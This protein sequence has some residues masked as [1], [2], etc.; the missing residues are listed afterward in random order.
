MKIKFLQA[1]NGD[2]FLLSYNDGTKNRNIL[3]DG[4]ITDTY[5]SQNTGNEGDLKTELDTIKN[6]GKSLDLLILTHIDN[7]HICGF[8]KW[9]EIDSE[10]HSNIKNV[11]FNSG[12]LIAEYFNEQENDDLKIGLKIFSDSQTG[13]HEAIKFEDYLIDKEIWDKKIIIQGQE[14]EECGM[15]IQILSPNETQ[16]K[17]LLKEYKE[18]TGD[19]AYTVGRGKDWNKDIKDFIEEENRPDFKFNQDSSVKNGSSISFILTLNDKFFLFL[20][21]SHPKGIVTQLKTL[22]YSKENPLE[23]EV[24]KVSHHGS[25]SNTNKELLEIVKT[26]NYIISTDSSGHNHP[27]KRTLARILNVNP[28][29]IFHFNYEHVRNEVFSAQD[30]QDFQIKARI[31]KEL[32]F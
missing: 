31:T 11:W 3:I 29:A 28:N 13:V 25:K 1:G 21:D 7:D 12:K 20:A 10:A 17:R 30:R 18:K 26:E 8:L 32:N 15:K 9:F 23:V 27:N 22:G 5:Y 2:S 16:L 4:G 6:N 14:Y 19:P 24:M